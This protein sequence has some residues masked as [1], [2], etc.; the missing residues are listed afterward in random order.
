MNQLLKNTFIKYKK[1]LI[2]LGVVVILASALIILNTNITNV[3]AQII[4]VT[5]SIS[6]LSFGTVFPGEELQGNFIVTYVEDGGDGI[7][8]KIIQKPK[9]CPEGN[10]DC[11]PGG[12]YRDL[13]PYLEKVSFEGEGD[14]TSSAFVGPISSDPSDNWT[15]YFKVPAIFGHVGQDHTGG[16][17]TE[18]GEY[19]CDIAIDID[20]EDICDPTQ[21]LAINSSFETPIVTATQ[22]WD[23]YDS[24]TTGL[25]WAVEWYDGSTSYGGQTRPEPAH[26]ELHRGVLGNAYSGEQYAEL[27]TDWDGPGGS[28]NNEPASVKIYQDIPTLPG[29][30]YDIK[31]Y[32]S[33]RPGHSDNILDFSWDGEVRDTVSADGTGNT[34]TSWVE[35][36][37]SFTA[38]G[39]LTRLEF[40]EK[41]APDS[42]GAFLD[43]VSVKCVLPQNNN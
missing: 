22:E 43:E 30:T 13:C 35:Y 23:I 42:L 9:P 41:G 33:P 36:S 11:G 32:F 25:G 1:L 14:A 21:N 15:I 20:I 37:Y 6:H 12:Y 40:I 27:D 5:V 3:S 2:T 4:P 31:F 17:V 19:G 24:G 28:L 10:P 8:Y 26:L 29:Q 16:I 34:N 7:A 39:S 38:A 18:S